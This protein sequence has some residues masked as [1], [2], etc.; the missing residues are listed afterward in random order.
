MRFMGDFFVMNS[1]VSGV[2][3]VDISFGVAYNME[4]EQQWRRYP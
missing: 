1:S 4:D 3:N 2:K